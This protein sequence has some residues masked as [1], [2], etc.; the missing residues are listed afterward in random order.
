MKEEIKYKITLNKFFENKNK[1]DMA[2]YCNT[3]MKAKILLNAF[4]KVG[5]KWSSGKS[6]TLYI[7]WEDYKDK[8]CYTNDNYF[9]DFDDVKEHNYKIYEF[10][11][12]D[13]EH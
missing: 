5:Q 9:T 2:I 4:D 3:E 8:T 1:R 11:E 13:L 7:N 12:V 6:Y 10:E